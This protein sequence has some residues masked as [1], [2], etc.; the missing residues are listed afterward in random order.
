MLSDETK[1]DLFAEFV[2]DY[3]LRLREALMASFGP[4]VGRD[5]AAEALA[6]GWEHWDR[7]VDMANPV[8]YLYR[9]GQTCGIRMKQRRS[10]PAL[11]AV[12]SQRLPWVEPEL[13]TALHRLPERQREVVLLLHAYEWT[14]AEVAELLG[15][16][17]ASVQT[18]A[19]RAMGRLRR[20][21]KVER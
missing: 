4:A 14:M 20:S 6:Y 9:V 17:K 3:E 11:P 1:T 16:S 21:L 5:A 15:I 10:A 12:D 7:L 19:D 18:H 13:P 8:G 2:A